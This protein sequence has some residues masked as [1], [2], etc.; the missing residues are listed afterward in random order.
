MRNQDAVFLAGESI[1]LGRTISAPRGLTAGFRRIA[2][3]AGAA[4]AADR[5]AVR[6]AAAAVMLGGL[7]YLVWWATGYAAS[8]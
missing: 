8:L 5:L 2:G 4:A 6:V 7:A 1:P 3:R